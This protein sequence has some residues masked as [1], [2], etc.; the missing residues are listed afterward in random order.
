MRVSHGDNFMISG[1][2]QTRK[3]DFLPGFV[4]QTRESF[5]VVLVSP[6]Q[7]NHFR[8]KREES[9]R[10]HPLIKGLRG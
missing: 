1:Y 6:P 7:E 4:Q 8:M 5:F 10:L 9:G 2:P 3:Q